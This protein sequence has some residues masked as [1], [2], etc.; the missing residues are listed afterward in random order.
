VTAPASGWATSALADGFKSSY[1]GSVRVATRSIPTSS[2]AS[3]APTSSERASSQASSHVG[4]IA[5]GAVGGAVVLIAIVA[6]SFFCL[7]S[8][9]KRAAQNAQPAMATT[10]HSP[11]VGDKHFSMSQGS[12]LYSHASPHPQSDYHG[13]PHAHESPSQH[14]RSGS[15]WSQPQ[16]LGFTSQYA[17]QQTY[18]PPPQDISHSP[19]GPHVELPSTQ[20][21]AHPAELPGVRSPKP[22]RGLY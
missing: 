6:L 5:G 14:H 11:T 1:P 21:P 22:M 19:Y 8:R 2:T 13:S 10:P 4:A 18:Y 17:Q 9:R 7:R 15:D 20:T 3:A 12:T 16:G